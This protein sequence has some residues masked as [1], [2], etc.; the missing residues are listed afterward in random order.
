MDVLREMV[1]LGGQ[2][3]SATETAASRAN[4]QITWNGLLSRLN[5][6]VV[7]AVNQATGTQI[8]NGGVINGKTLNTGYTPSRISIAGP[9]YSNPNY[10]LKLKLTY[11]EIK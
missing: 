3:G 11:T 5:D 10:K 4:I 6:I 1:R 2:A 9:N 7:G 8:L